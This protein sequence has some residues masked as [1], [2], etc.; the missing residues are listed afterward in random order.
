[1][2]A[3]GWLLN[4]GFA[5]SAANPEDEN[6]ANTFASGG[7]LEELVGYNVHGGPNDP[8]GS[9]LDVLDGDFG[10][11]TY[12]EVGKKNNK[13]HAVINSNA[14]DV[15]LHFHAEQGRLDSKRIDF[16]FTYVAKNIGIALTSDQSTYE[17]YETNQF[18]FCGVQVHAYGTGDTTTHTLDD[19]ESI[20]MVIGHRGSSAQSCI[21]GKQTSSDASSVED[22]GT[23]TIGTGVTRCDM[24]LRGLWSDTNSRWYVEC[25]Y[26]AVGT[27]TWTLYG[28]GDAQNGRE[29]ASSG[30]IWSGASNVNECDF[31]SGEAYIGLI[32]YAQ[33]TTGVDGLWCGTCDEITL[34]DG[35]VRIMNNYRQRRV[36]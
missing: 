14:N 19:T 17:T 29:G 32:T 4:L 35:L 23:D 15:T 27:S 25:A 9:P 1:M 2:A 36:A 30:E 7:T 13:Y 34:N 12:L 31:S 3:L 16:P 10:S 26:R 33:S 6:H 5:G 18:A 22:E 8:G 20:H 11:K 24:R 21:E 28:A